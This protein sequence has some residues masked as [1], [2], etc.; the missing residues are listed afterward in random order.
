M[1]EVEAF[2]ID[3]QMLKVSSIQPLL[4]FPWPWAT[5]AGYR[6]SWPYAT[7]IRLSTGHEDWTSD[8]EDLSTSVRSRSA[9][10]Y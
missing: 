2:D 8:E 3:L 9:Q 7:P 4:R 10:D 5:R 6:K 1:T